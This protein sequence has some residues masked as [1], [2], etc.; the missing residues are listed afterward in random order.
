MEMLVEP[1]GFEDVIFQFGICSS[2]SSNG[3]IKRTQY[4]RAWIVY[5]IFSEALIVTNKIPSG[6]N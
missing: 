3:V 2:G 4:N 5:S 6:G 1:S